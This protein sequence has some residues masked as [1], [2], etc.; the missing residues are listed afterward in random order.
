[1]N[2]KKLNPILRIKTFIDE[3]TKRAVRKELNLI[4]HHCGD[5]AIDHHM[6]SDSW[7]VIKVD[8]GPASCYLK[9]I[10]LGK[11]DLRDV[12]HFMAQYDRSHIDAAPQI[13]HEFNRM[14]N[15]KTLYNH[16]LFL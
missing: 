11:S 2:W 9:F 1:M 12:Q 6:M 3:R 10:D 4:F 15:E 16:N 5:V 13:E 7:A 8:S 14:Y